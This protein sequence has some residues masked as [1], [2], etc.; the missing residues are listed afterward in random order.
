M[1]TMKE[2][3][4]ALSWS[5]KEFNSYQIKDIYNAIQTDGFQSI[6]EFKQAKE[7]GEYQECAWYADKNLI[8]LIENLVEFDEQGI[9][10][11]IN[12]TYS[13]RISIH[14]LQQDEMY[15]MITGYQ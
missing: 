12:S 15:L 4:K 6:E 10:D 3:T 7:D 8:P 13:E 9:V 5:M 2:F 1:I 11:F 14:Y